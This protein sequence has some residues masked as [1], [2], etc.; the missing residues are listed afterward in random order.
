[1]KGDHNK[2]YDEG[3]FEICKEF[4]EDDATEA[5]TVITDVETETNSVNVLSNKIYLIATYWTYPFGGGE[6]FMYDT[7]AWAEKLGMKP[8]WIAFSN[9]KNE[10]FEQFELKRHRH[11]TIIHVP[12]GFSVNALK[13]WLHIIKPSVVHH[14]GMFRE[15]FFL[16]TEELRIEF[17]TGFH[18]WTG[19]IVLHEDKKSIKII[20]NA[21]Y[22][23]VDPEFE[24]LKT[25]ERCTF[26]CA[27]KFV[28]ECFKAVTSTDIPDI[29]LPASSINRYSLN[30][31]TEDGSTILHDPWDSK[32]VTMINIHKDKGGHI[33][34]HLLKFCLNVHFLCVRTEHHSEELDELIKTEI[35]K[36]N[37]LAGTDPNIA[38]C[39]FLERTTDVKSIYSKAKIILCTSHVDETFCRV[40]NEAMMNGI[41]VLTTHRGNIKYL[42]GDTTPVLDP[43]K[44]EEWVG[45]V[46]RIY[47]DREA[48]TVMS[49]AMRDKY[50]ESSEDVAEKQFGSLMRRVVTKSKEFNVGIFTP[51]CDQGLGIQSRNYYNILKKSGLFR[52]SVF[53]L[54]PYNAPNCKA[55][56]KNEK[57]W[58]VANVYYSP[59]CR[60]D[61]T[62]PEIFEF[63]RK[64]NIG[65]MIMPETCWPRIFQIAKLLREI[66]V[67]TYAV[68][69][70]EIV[71][72]DE[73]YKHNYFHKILANNRLCK[74]V[75][76]VLDVPVPYIGY[77]VLNTTDTSVEIGT[78]EKIF[79]E[80]GTINFLFIG[81]MNAFS[82]KHVLEVC[83][84]FEIAY[85]TNPNINLTVTIQ[86]TNSLED[87]L[88]LKIEQYTKHP[89]IKVV[90]SH[91]SYGDIINLY[92]THH[93]SIQVSKHEGL[94]LGFYEAVTTNTP[95][96][97]LNTPPHNEIII[98][99]V[100]GWWV[101][102]YYKRMIDNK[103]PLFG[104]AY[105]N[106]E[107]LAK[108]ILEISDRDTVT[109]TIKTLRQDYQTRL[110]P[111][112]FMKRFVAE[113]CE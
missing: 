111:N 105:F 16:A 99:G 64:Y 5:E 36:R 80:S 47:A 28:Q 69:N 96:L 22:H 55:L 92:H 73:I 61:V 46:N 45:Q 109:N 88:K 19:G 98:D 68:P 6:E 9:S 37:E 76:S 82:R 13:N 110:N 63:C 26:Y 104:S 84:G 4:F 34:Y 65:K 95:V 71:R 112:L 50:R 62:D 52:V 54:K 94:G 66:G 91:L 18:F 8:Y 24:F 101:D 25:K 29:V 81:G 1:M 57:E 32:Y 51:W 59:N 113:I 15:K 58:D 33:F 31:K 60:E 40:V 38:S 87:Q 107:D 12:G 102:C 10:P 67:K 77:G 2:N 93:I 42:V 103:D 85:R 106:S 23:R 108:K 11:G 75:F 39:V 48:Y 21:E 79:N 78:Q 74:R 44:P 72:K 56:Q 90:Q 20:E 43:E 89:G 30:H 83:E 100:N 53:A 35:D 49:H 27:S 7:M 14:Q 3:S 41:P 17:V 70:I 86:M 97:T